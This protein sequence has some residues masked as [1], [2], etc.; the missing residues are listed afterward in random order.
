MRPVLPGVD[1][2]TA[3]MPKTG[4]NGWAIA[5]F[6]LG[7]VSV[8]LLSIIFGI[9]AL[10]KIGDGPRRGQGAGNHRHLHV[11]GLDRGRDRVLRL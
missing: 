4:T 6:V 5:S 2:A 8:S 11:R 3:D 7:L 9:V 10:A 1:Y